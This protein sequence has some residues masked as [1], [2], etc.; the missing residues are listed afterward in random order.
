MD[1]ATFLQ[2][3]RLMATDVRRTTPLTVSL[4]SVLGSIPDVG[5]KIFLPEGDYFLYAHLNQSRDEVE[6]VGESQR[7]VIHCMNGS[8]IYW[9]GNRGRLHNVKIVC[10]RSPP[11]H[12]V[13]VVGDNW[14]SEHL[15]IVGGIGG[16]LLAGGSCTLHHA[17]VES[18]NGTAVVSTGD[19]NAVRFGR[20]DASPAVVEV[21]S[22]GSANSI[23]HNYCVG[24]AF[25]V[26]GAG[27]TNFDNLVV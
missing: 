8:G 12:L 26:T 11:A 1:E 3:R 10:D 4:A 17:R 18:Q 23:V 5:G 9:S 24:G 27:S 21:D 14:E 19:H 15:R 20:F 7:T 16:I 2:I 13:W 22:T 25:S 6:I